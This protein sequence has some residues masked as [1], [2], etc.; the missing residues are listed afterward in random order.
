MPCSLSKP[1][2]R[3][4]W[5]T[6][7]DLNQLGKSKPYGTPL[8]GP[9]QVLKSLCSGMES[10]VP[11]MAVKGFIPTGPSLNLS[12]VPNIKELETPNVYSPIGYLLQSKE[13]ASAESHLFTKQNHMESEQLPQGVMED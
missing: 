7:D 6:W 11:S 4:I 12:N 1:Q 13:E 5:S 8:Q 2:T 10:P 9:S 3:V